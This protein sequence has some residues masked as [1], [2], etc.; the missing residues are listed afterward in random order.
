[1]SHIAAIVICLVNACWGSGS[2]VLG[3]APLHTSAYT[4]VEPQPLLITGATLIDGTGADSIEDAWIHVNGDLIAAVGRGRAPAIPDA[5]VISLRG[6]TVI[7]GLSDMHVHLVDLVG[8][9]WMLTLFLAHGVTTIRDVGNRFDNLAAIRRWMPENEPVPRLYISGQMMDGSSRDLT[10]LTHGSSLQSELEDNLAFGVDF[11]KIHNWF[12]T[13]ALEQIIDFA[14]EHDIYLAGHVPLCMT[15]VAAIDAGMKILEHVRLRP[16]EVLDDP[17]IVARYPVDLV[18]LKRTGYWAYF[19]PDTSALKR[20]LE[21]WEKRRD[22]F[23]VDPTFVVRWAGAY[24][25]EC[26]ELLGEKLELVSTAMLRSWRRSVGSYGGRDLNPEEREGIKASLEKMMAFI[27]MA[28]ERGIRMLTGT[29]TPTQ[30]V[31]PG[32]SIHPTG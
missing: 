10:F 13:L 9:K 4:Q 27:G 12:S 20:T 31:I 21:A 7:P 28:H 6:K 8:A 1:M 23:F 32:Y 15:T 14:N 5:R 26:E 11:L 18:L 17:E 22:R 3:A 25:Y 30:W 24:E 2:A 16:W 29:D 19:D